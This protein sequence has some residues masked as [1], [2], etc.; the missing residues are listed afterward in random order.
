M[1]GHVGHP[2][3]NAHVALRSRTPAAGASVTCCDRY[4]GRECQRASQSRNV[5]AEI[6]ASGI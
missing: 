1:M 2:L 4:A 5:G 3:R 6:I